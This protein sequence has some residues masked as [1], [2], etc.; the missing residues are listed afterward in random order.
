MTFAALLVD[1]ARSLVL[2]FEQN[3]MGA[4]LFILLFRVWLKRPR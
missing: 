3:P 2:I 1:Q 4:L